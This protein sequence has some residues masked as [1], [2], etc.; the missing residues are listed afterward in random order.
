MID[1]THNPRVSQLLGR[2]EEERRALQRDDERARVTRER[3]IAGLFGELGRYVHWLMR[4]DPAS[5]ARVDAEARAWAD[6]VDAQLAQGGRIAA[7]PAG[8]PPR[9]VVA[10]APDDDRPTGELRPE[11]TADSGRRSFGGGASD[12]AEQELIELGGD[13]VI[14]LEGD[15]LPD[16]EVE[17]LT[18]GA[19]GE[20]TDSVAAAA[21]D[22]ADE[23]WVTSLRDLLKMLGPPEPLRLDDAAAAIA[24][25][26]LSNAT[27]QMEE[28][29]IG[30]PDTAQQALA[31]LI[32][33][34]ARHLS[35]RTAVDVELRMVIGR[36]RRFHSARRL[37][38]LNALR[39]DGRPDHGSWEADARRWWANL[40]QSG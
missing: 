4:Q 2:V 40:Q 25:R 22:P 33:S 21:V 29:W 36:L 38:A 13:E 39:D 3:T 15:E 9:A 10:E 23:G 16:V 26:R 31:G 18:D 14:A 1:I 7:R 37:P 32:G 17:P 35:E 8:P 28:R 19:D 6:Q 11:A 30:Y 24:A 27:N 5:L 12:S 20:L 34:R